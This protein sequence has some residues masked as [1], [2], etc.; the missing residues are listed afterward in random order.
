VGDV[1]LV[2][3][4]TRTL[5]LV[6]AILAV[7]KSLEHLVM[8][9]PAAW[10]VLGAPLLIGGLLVTTGSLRP[11]AGVIAAAALV[12]N[13]TPAY[14]NHLNLLMWVALTLLLFGDEEQRRLVLRCQLTLL[15]GFAAAAKLWPDWLSGEALLEYTWVAPLLADP[16]VVAIA[17]TTIA[18]EALLAVAVW[19]PRR[20]GVTLAAALHLA[21]LFFTHSEPVDVGRIAVFGVL[22]LAVWLTATPGGR[23]LLADRYAHPVTHG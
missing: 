8:F 6:V 9:G 15:Y 16:A 4:T 2:A 20:L 10:V 17:W 18:V 7:Y 22:S 14:R 19:S 21:F 23:R 3:V 11:G 1:L 5:A 13:L 12:V